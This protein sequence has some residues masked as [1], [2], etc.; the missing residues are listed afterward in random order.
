MSNDGFKFKNGVINSIILDGYTYQNIVPSKSSLRNSIYHKYM[1]R[2]NYNYDDVIVKGDN[3]DDIPGAEIIEPE[4]ALMY[5]DTMVNIA[6]ERENLYNSTTKKVQTQKLGNG[7]AYILDGIS[8]KA[9][10]RG[11]TLKYILP[12][13]RCFNVENYHQDCISYFITREVIT[14]ENQVF[15]YDSIIE[16]DFE[17]GKEYTLY[18]PQI[19]GVKHNI[20]IESDNVDTT[21]KPKNNEYIVF[22]FNESAKDNTIKVIQEF[23]SSNPVGDVVMPFISKDVIVVEGNHFN[24]PLQILDGGLHGISLNDLTIKTIGKNLFNIKSA[25]LGC[26][27]DEGRLDDDGSYFKDDNSYMRSDYIQII[28]SKT[29]IVSLTSEI[30]GELYRPVWSW[31]DKNRNFIRQDR[32]TDAVPVL[33]ATAPENAEYLILHVAIQNSDPKIILEDFVTGQIEEGSKST[34]YETYKENTILFEYETKEDSI[35][36]G[37]LHG[38]DGVYDELDVNTLTITRRVIE[39]I[40]GE[41]KQVLF[42]LPEE[43]IDRVIGRSV[44]NIAKIDFNKLTPDCWEMVNVDDELHITIKLVNAL[45][46]DDKETIQHL[47]DGFLEIKTSNTYVINKENLYLN[48]EDDSIS[49]VVKNDNELYTILGNSENISYDGISPISGQGQDKT[50]YFISEDIKLAEFDLSKAEQGTAEYNELDNLVK[51]LKQKYV[52]TYNWMK[53]LSVNSVKVW[54]ETDL[55]ISSELDVAELNAVIELLAFKD[56]YLSFNP[57]RH[58]TD[59]RREFVPYYDLDENGNIQYDEDNCIMYKKIPLKEIRTDDY[60]N[61]IYDEEGNEIYDIVYEDGKIVYE[62][63]PELDENGNIKIDEDGHI[64]YR[65]EPKVDKDGNILYGKLD[66]VYIYEG[67]IKIISENG[68]DS[69]G[70]VP[71]IPEMEVTIPSSNSFILS[72]LKPDTDYTLSNY[73]E[74][75]Y[76]IIDGNKYTINNNVFRTPST[77]QNKMVVYQNV[78]VDPDKIMIIEGN[79][80]VKDIP[81]FEGKMEVRSP[82]VQILGKNLF[83]RKK[84]DT[85]ELPILGADPE[86]Y[87]STHFIKVEPDEDYVKVH[88]EGDN[89]IANSAT[90]EFYTEDK[91]AI[92]NAATAYAFKTPKDACYIRF[93]ID[94]SD[95]FPT[96]IET[97]Q[98]EQ[99]YIDSFEVFVD[100]VT[101][102][103]SKEDYIKENGEVVHAPVFSYSKYIEINNIIPEELTMRSIGNIR[104][105]YNIKT[106]HFTKNVE[107]IVFT[108]LESEWEKVSSGE[109]TLFRYL[110]TLPMTDEINMASNKYNYMESDSEPCIYS[111]GSYIYLRVPTAKIETFAKD[112]V[113]IRYALARENAPEPV[114]Y[115]VGFRSIK[116]G[117]ISVSSNGLLPI[118]EYE[119]LTENS[120]HIDGVQ[121]NEI[122][123]LRW[124][125]DANKIEIII[126]GTLTDY[127][128]VEKANDSHV[129]PPKDIDNILIVK[130]MTGIKDLM[131]ILGDVKGLVIPYF[132]GIRTTADITNTIP[133]KY[134]KLRNDSEGT[135]ELV[136]SENISLASLPDGKKEELVINTVHSIAT[137]KRKTMSVKVNPETEVISIAQTRFNEAPY[138]KVTIPLDVPGIN[139]LYCDNLDVDFVFIDE[140]GLNLIIKDI[141]VW[142]RETFNSYLRTKPNGE[143]N[144]LYEIKDY[145]RVS[146]N[147]EIKEPLSADSDTEF[148]FIRDPETEMPYYNIRFNQTAVSYI[149]NSAELM[150]NKLISIEDANAENGFIYIS[151]NANIWDYHNIDNILKLS[152]KSNIEFY[153]DK[154]VIL[155]GDTVT[156]NFFDL[157]SDEYELS[158]TPIIDMVIINEDTVKS[159]FYSTGEITIFGCKINKEL[160]NKRVSVRVKNTDQ[161]DVVSVSGGAAFN[162]IELVDIQLIKVSD[163]TQYTNIEHT[164][165]YVSYNDSVTPSFTS[166]ASKGISYTGVP[167]ITA[168]NNGDTIKTNAIVK[169]MLS[170][171]GKKY[172]VKVKPE[173]EYTV[174]F[175][176]SK[177]EKVTIDLAGS[178]VECIGSKSISITTP[179]ELKHS[180]LFIKGSRCRVSNVTVVEGN[181]DS[182]YFKYI[183][184]V[185]TY[186]AN[187]LKLDLGGQGTEKIELLSDLRSLGDTADIYDPDSG[188]I[189]RCIDTRILNGSDDENWEYK[190]IEDGC[191]IFRL[192]NLTA[193]T[194][195]MKFHGK[196]YPE[197]GETCYMDEENHIVVKI[198]KFTLDFDENPSIFKSYLKTCPITVYY[199]SEEPKELYDK[200]MERPLEFTTKEI[201]PSN[202]VPSRLIFRTNASYNVNLDHSKYYTI[203]CICSKDKIKVLTANS[204]EYNMKKDGISNLHTL[205]LRGSEIGSYIDFETE[206]S[207]IYNVMVTDANSSLPYGTNMITGITQ[208]TIVTGG[209][210]LIDIDNAKVESDDSI[211]ATV[212]GADINVQN[213]DCIEGS[214][215]IKVSINEKFE[216]IDGYYVASAV[217]KDFDQGEDS[218]I[219]HSMRAVLLDLTGNIIGESSNTINGNDGII[220]SKPFLVNK[221]NYIGGIAII[222]DMS[223][224]NAGTIISKV[225]YTLS[226]LSLK[227]FR[228]L[229]DAEEYEHVYSEY[230]EYMEIPIKFEKTLYALSDRV[231]DI[232]DYNNDRTVFNVGIYTPSTNTQIKYISKN[233]FMIENAVS[234]AQPSGEYVFSNLP[235]GDGTLEFSNAH[236]DDRN[237]T[238]VLS[239]ISDNLDD[240]GA[241]AFMEDWLA[242]SGFMMLYQLDEPNIVQ[243][244]R[245]PEIG[246][247]ANAGIYTIGSSVKP[248][249]DWKSEQIMVNISST[250]VYTV[251]FEVL[252]GD[253]VEG[254]VF[255]GPNVTRKY[256][257]VLG[258]NRVA[259]S[260]DLDTINEC[261]FIELDFPNIEIGRV[262][263]VPGDNTD[264][265]LGDQLANVL[266]ER[267]IFESALERDTLDSGITYPLRL[268]S[269]QYYERGN[270]Q[271]YKLRTRY[272]E[273]IE[274]PLRGLPNNKCDEIVFDYEGNGKIVRNVGRFI[275]NM[276]NIDNI[277][278]T[279]NSLLDLFEIAILDITDCAETD[280]IGGSVMCDKLPVIDRKYSPSK[281]CIT[282]T[283]DR[284]N[285][286]FQIPFTVM[287]EYAGNT[288]EEKVR[289]YISSKGNIEFVYQ[290]KNPGVVEDY[291]IL[292]ASKFITSSL[293]TLIGNDFN[294]DL[295]DETISLNDNELVRVHN[296]KFVGRHS[297]NTIPPYINYSGIN[298]TFEENVINSHGCYTILF[299]ADSKDRYGKENY[300]SVTFC[301]NTTSVKLL[302]G[303]NSYKVTIET[304]YIDK[305]NLVISCLGVEFT[306]IMVFEGD[307]KDDDNLPKEFFSGKKSVGEK[308]EG[309]DYYKVEI[310]GTGGNSL[311]FYIESPLQRIDDEIFDSIEYDLYARRYYH[312][313]R[314]DP[315]TGVPHNEAKILEFVG[316]NNS[317]EPQVIVTGDE[318]RIVESTCNVKAPF[319]LIPLEYYINV[320]PNTR[321][322]MAFIGEIPS[323]K[324]VIKFNDKI[325]KTEESS[326][327]VKF[328]T[329]TFN[330]GPIGESKLVFEVL[331][332]KF[333]ND[334]VKIQYL[335]V[336]EASTPFQEDIKRLQSL[337]FDTRGIESVA[338]QK[339]EVNGKEYHYIDLVAYD[340]N[341]FDVMALDQ[342]NLAGVDFISKYTGTIRSVYVGNG[343]AVSVVD[344]VETPS[345]ESIQRLP[346]I[347]PN[348]EYTLSFDLQVMVGSVL[349][350]TEFNVIGYVANDIDEFDIKGFTI[351]SVKDLKLT[352]ALNKV[353]C[354]FKSDFEVHGLGFAL[355]TDSSSE[356]KTIVELS[357]IQLE[358]NNT[359]TECEGCNKFVQRILLEQPLRSLP[360]GIRDAISISEAGR[361]IKRLTSIVEFSGS[362]W[363]YDYNEIENR[364]CLTAIIDTRMEDNVLKNPL[365]K[366]SYKID[367]ETGDKSY[368]NNFICSYPISSINYPGVFANLELGQD[369][370]TGQFKLT[371]VYN[372]CLIEE[373][374]IKAVLRDQ[375][376]IL[377]YQIDD[378]L[379]I[380]QDLMYPAEEF[381][382]E[383]QQI[384]NGQLTLA[385]YDAVKPYITAKVPQDTRKLIDDYKTEVDTLREEVDGLRELNK[386]M[387][388]LIAQAAPLYAAVGELI[389]RSIMFDDP[390]LDDEGNNINGSFEHDKFINNM[391]PFSFL[392]VPFFAQQVRSNMMDYDEIENIYGKQ[393]KDRVEE[394]VKKLFP[395]AK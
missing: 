265:A 31:F 376:V 217:I 109:T 152:S 308:V 302:E 203:S 69:I 56:G 27:T 26:V 278:I 253:L 367:P 125:G 364:T 264:M 287:D 96:D 309:E 395:D 208:F 30:V 257:P 259:V 372:N 322:T 126:P 50:L 371:A 101:G 38:F 215:I 5:G 356:R 121:P 29:Y 43:H 238:I 390:D 168:L 248:S 310:A 314:I 66:F 115:S 292:E 334:P 81:Y 17:K 68:Y 42:K 352:N 73:G 261:N 251:V 301:E 103:I 357:N 349:D 39:E 10:V 2:F 267:N 78:P 171:R 373:E 122:Y 158:F 381:V 228:T 60:G 188:I 336:F 319:T 294:I 160:E 48:K 291:H 277:K 82:Q 108:G 201:T 124:S 183:N 54:C 306:D 4:Y 212:N 112:P 366:L 220:L 133:A 231:Y 61:I 274:Q 385:V 392:F 242:S 153:D 53:W 110:I 362:D 339:V 333:K 205:T 303:K 230:E 290:L 7:E 37:V 299:T 276:N 347:L 271:Y 137:F 272:T 46:S 331:P 138:T 330:S 394:E 374:Y 97:L 216:G 84:L 163:R 351:K 162:R 140:N 156:G 262:M 340:K 293:N 304:N 105:V 184:A 283:E 368:L 282:N 193:K 40:D 225:K 246:I 382:I 135:F 116:D 24:R 118:I 219:Q 9:I 80:K 391:E 67:E 117:T 143:I 20:S 177:D 114:Q 370:A 19:K 249:L 312:I 332:E 134:S 388:L 227:Y 328:F 307:F 279:E 202:E 142:D 243:G 76:V 14:E 33:T 164:S 346:H 16:G 111:D 323:G 123:T 185:G 92:T 288:L 344:N 386:T 224:R 254:N 59:Y 74:S 236:F 369:S 141:F 173:T 144:V 229:E 337:K 36:N 86:K 51:S 161:I 176:L 72:M 327:D 99:R 98:L 211:I 131:L 159:N 345:R 324:L 383:Q 296:S 244:I 270:T 6:T 8:A 321:Y 102:E 255:I 315:E 15:S 106:K 353:A 100:E 318:K 170:L 154:L 91:I 150:G 167:A 145:T 284:K 387:Q 44:S 83:D 280:N 181:S 206:L 95:M 104:D 209:T 132:T 365:P 146:L 175:K 94:K 232:I 41:G 335:A 325:L 256:Q 191:Q 113:Y 35:F 52:F 28:P 198:N 359:A 289:N 320:K 361:Q 275:F 240:E 384:C 179:K 341:I 147:T 263:V 75:E 239:N 342:D 70:C 65:K 207:T 45:D 313:Q 21:E 136:H 12:K 266:F 88:I 139:N 196:F 250:D 64:V 25:K 174:S 165:A 273:K 360:N 93:N 63:E 178:T 234:D 358:R 379:E 222:D 172:R 218:R 260:L 11:E 129:T 233:E 107:E 194:P 326:S 252:D 166:G 32:T 377:I 187:T 190:G 375:P 77:I 47:V 149:S 297:M 348:I 79:H 247:P 389:R 85:N 317:T 213:D 295:K 363:S 380:N 226:E 393:V 221:G 189:D 89:Y 200:L 120:F 235:V 22:K 18:V 285:L 157:G 127:D 57:I 34:E 55:R 354:T 355:I 214:S 269:H 311:V 305:P 316:E 258:V 182:S 298:Y 223:L 90:V 169:P 197:L 343:D 241:R 180:Y 195:D 204:G 210:N 119:V 3:H 286:Q 237:I 155:P 148:E 49:V 151:G 378:D 192:V 268:A 281:E 58:I 186:E 128:F 338:D 300:I 130:D 13:A 87:Y 71:T 350:I 23:T 199:T 62:R 1:Q 329:H 245:K